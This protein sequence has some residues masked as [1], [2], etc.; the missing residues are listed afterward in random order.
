MNSFLNPH[1]GTSLTGIIDL[2]VHSISL[3][4]ENDEPENIKNTF[5]HNDNIS[6][7]EPYDVQI[8]ETGNNFITMYQ[9]TGNIS[10]NMVPG[11][12]SLLNYMNENFYNKDEPAVNNHEYHVTKKQ[13]TEETHNIYN[14]DKSKSYNIKHNLYTD[15]QHYHKKQN[16]NNSIIN[17]ITKKNTINNT[18]KKGTSIGNGKIKTSTMNKRK[19]QN[20]K[21]YRGQGNP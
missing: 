15:E 4:Q 20:F 17:N 3:F 2:T 18:F 6:I 7:A 21:K 13:Y 16:I 12:E 9:F 1:N 8:D 19:K 5:I 10:D 14:I 11:L